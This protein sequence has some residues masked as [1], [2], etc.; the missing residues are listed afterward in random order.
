MKANLLK[1]PATNREEG[2]VW[3]ARLL[4]VTSFPSPPP[5]TGKLQAL[6]T[7]L[8]QIELN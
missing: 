3:L 7:E 1:F 5:A 4:D 6:A 2:E 8:G